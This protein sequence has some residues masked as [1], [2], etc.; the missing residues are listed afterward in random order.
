MTEDRYTVDG[1][2]LS[3]ESVL[4]LN[5]RHGWMQYG[6]SQSDV[7]NAFA[8]NAVHKFLESAKEAQEVL[9]ETGLTPRELAEE[10]N[11]LSRK[12]SGELPWSELKTV[13]DVINAEAV[14]ESIYTHNLSFPPGWK[15]VEINLLKERAQVVF[16]VDHLPTADEGRA[17][18]Y[19]LELAQRC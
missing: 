16:M 10:L 2:Y 19:S 18:K 7:S 5:E 3:R 11:E 8:N 15:Y 13:F 14:L 6:D 12:Y 4:Q 1:D 9:T 17:V